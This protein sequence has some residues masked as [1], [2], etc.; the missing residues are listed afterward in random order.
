MKKHLL[1]FLLLI[2][3]FVSAQ[4]TKQS[5]P[6]LNAYEFADMDEKTA[7]SEL[8]KKYPNTTFDS[9]DGLYNYF[10]KTKFDFIKEL[11]ISYGVKPQG[12]LQ[13][14]NASEFVCGV[15]LKPKKDNSPACGEVIPYQSNPV[16]EK[17]V[18]LARII[19]EKGEMPDD[20][21]LEL[22]VYKNELDLFK[23]LLEKTAKQPDPS[24]YARWM[25]TAADK[26]YVDFVKY[27]ISKGISANSND[28]G[29]FYVIYRA[30][31]Y[32][33]IF[34]YLIEQGADINVIG[35]K[36]MHV[37]VHAAREGCTEVIQYLLEKGADPNKK[38]GNMSAIEMAQKYNQKNGK[39][40]VSLMKKYK[41]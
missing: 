22:C 25:E 35:Y 16:S 37:I 24:S 2:A 13:N 26:G 21:A 11:L 17:K 19:M 12:F 34:H 5:I 8:K 20:K 7:I 32:P 38:Y 41:K 29:G 10:F 33:E 4:N 3:N 28:G 15:G 40:V 23:V 14:L 6:V 27:F 39:E 1:I 36:D 18:E 30:V 31:K 9:V